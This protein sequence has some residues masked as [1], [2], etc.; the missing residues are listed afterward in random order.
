VPRPGH[1]GRLPGSGPHRHLQGRAPHERGRL[2]RLR[3]LLLPRRGLRP[4]RLLLLRGPQREAHRPRWLLPR[5]ERHALRR[6]GR[7]HQAGS[8][9]GWHQVLGLPCAPLRG[10]QR[11][12]PGRRRPALHQRRGRSLLQRHPRRGRRLRRPGARVRGG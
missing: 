11:V 3:G 2:Q 10:Q 5:R 7:R 6:Q 12:P 4:L 1:R 9:P 8:V